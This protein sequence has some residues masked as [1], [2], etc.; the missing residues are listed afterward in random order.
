MKPGAE[1]DRIQLIRDLVAGGRLADAEMTCRSVLQDGPNGQ[2]SELLGYIAQQSGFYE[3]AIEQCVAAN[4]SG[5]RGWSNYLVLGLSLRALDRHA[6]AVAALSTAHQL[7]PTRSDVVMLLLEETFV[8]HGFESAE[9][10]YRRIAAELISADIARFW[11][12]LSFERAEVPFVSTE[13]DIACEL[14]TAQSWAHSRGVPV[15]QVEGVDAIPV[16]SPPVIGACTQHYKTTIYSNAPYVVE[17]PDA[18]LFS[19]SNI[20]LTADGVALDETGAHE[21][22]GQFV[23][24]QSDCAV[25]GQRGA[26]VL[27][28]TSAFEIRTLDTGIMLSGALSQAFGHWVPEYLPKLQFYE[29]HPEFKELPIIVDAGMPQSHYDYL[30]C[31]AKNPVIKIPPNVAFRCRRLIYAPPAT[32]FPAHLFPNSIPVHEVGPVSPRSYQYL[33]S[34]VEATLGTPKSN[35]KKYFLSRRNMAWRRLSNDAEV[36][37]FL[38]ARGYETIQIETLSFGEQV[39]LFQGASHIVASNGSSLQNIIFSDP[40]VDLLVLS[41]SNLVNWGAFYAQTGALGYHSRFV[42][43]ESIGDPSRKHADYVVPISTLEAALSS[44]S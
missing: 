34:R 36:A 25:I 17:L 13:G 7:M 23:S 33:K 26:R 8:T 40:L 32:F 41:Q 31:I 9:A 12:K 20:V 43:G 38:E 11:R 37:A 16:E 22:Y 24:H 21:R 44:S 39:R 14:M 4:E 29:H 15:T 28:D 3:L 18:T 10:L 6:E 30:S 5:L 27:L 19:K 35:G 1:V 2:A 42:C